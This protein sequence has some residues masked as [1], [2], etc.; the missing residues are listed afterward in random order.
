M[1]FLKMWLLIPLIIFGLILSST[2]TIHA[3]SSAVL[4]ANASTNTYKASLLKDIEK[5]IQEAMGKRQNTIVIKYKGSTNKLLDVIS[6]YIDKAIENDEYLNY[7]F[8]G[9]NMSY[10]A[11]GT[12]ITITLKFT[13]YETAAEMKYVDQQVN[14]ILSKIISP[15]MNNHEKVKA[16]HDYLVL[17]LGYD[18]TLISNSP[19]TALT[20][21]ITACN[22]YAMLAYK[23]L[24]KLGFDVRLISGTASSQAYKTQNHAWN[25]VKLDDKWYHLDVTWDDPVPD[26][27]GRIFYD[28][29]LLTDKEISKN[30]SWKQGGINGEEKPYPAA[31]TAYL[32]L[33]QSKLSSTN[34][35][36]RYQELMVTIGLHYL[37]PENTASRLI[38][39]SDMIGNQFASYNNE[40]NLRYIDNKGDL[41]TNLR[42]I[43]YDNA[44]KHKVKSWSF[45]TLPY[46]RGTTSF[47]QLV[48]ISDI[49]YQNDPPKD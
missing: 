35:A 31:T 37:L 6:G 12:D 20:K 28:Y 9:V 25:L 49:V 41:S 45:V 36:K 40:F 48:M 34:E 15:E 43:I 42:Q 47:D 38:E 14:A 5:I 4:Y 10:K 18:T 1:R 8:R 17:N 33:L 27:A 24:K 2:T 26:E 22:G 11:Y 16:V 7:S 19:Y 44:V 32:D 29:Y 39:L 23:M 21:G 46:I 13:Y 30:H 3:G